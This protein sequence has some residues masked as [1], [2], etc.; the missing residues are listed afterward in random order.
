MDDASSA[1]RYSTLYALYFFFKKKNEWTTCFK[2]TRIDKYIYIHVLKKEET[3]D[4]YI[5][6]S[7]KLLWLTFF[8]I[9]Q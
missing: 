5:G 8:F 7:Y 1:T 3:M 4:R 6:F 9:G 2:K